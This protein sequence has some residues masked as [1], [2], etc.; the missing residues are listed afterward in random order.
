MAYYTL[1][2]KWE[3]EDRLWE[4]H[5]GSAIRGEV[6]MERITLEDAE[7]CHAAKMIR[8]KTD[9]QEEIERAV[10]ILNDVEMNVSP[11]APRSYLPPY[12]QPKD[13]VT[14]LGVMSAIVRAGDVREIRSNGDCTVIAMDLLDIVIARVNRACGFQ[15]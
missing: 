12:L 4:I 14:I 2:V 13:M 9:A 5:F 7:E 1:L 15:P 10:K 8:T 6:E 11:E 3:K